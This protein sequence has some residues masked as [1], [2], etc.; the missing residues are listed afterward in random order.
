[1]K[2]IAAVI[3][4]LFLVLFFFLAVQAKTALWLGLFAASLLAALVFGRLYCG[5]VCPMN[6]CMIPA[7]WLSKKL[8]L[9]VKDT[10]RWLKNGYFSWIALAVSI[11]AMLLSKRFLHINLPVLLIWVAVSVLVSL[12][13]RPAVF[14]N[15]IC[16]FGALQRTFGRF[17]RMS[18]KVD[19]SA[20]VGCGLC[21]RVC[22]SDAIAVSGPNKKA[23]INVSLCHQCTNCRQACPK[24][25]IRYTGVKKG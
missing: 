16:P 19:I 23:I 8:K 21:E 25:A 7:E 18:E 13:Y 3:R 10:P 14:H 12:R 9:Q 24:E 20:C 5:Y 11:A 6:T 15:T 22:P 17:A 4:L 1:M 2:Y